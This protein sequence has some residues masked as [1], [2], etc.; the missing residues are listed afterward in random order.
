MKRIIIYTSFLSIFISNTFAQDLKLDESVSIKTEEPR[1]KKDI[2]ISIL[3]RLERYVKTEVMFR[4]PK[5]NVFLFSV[6]LAIDSIGHVENAFFSGNIVNNQSEFITVNDRLLADFK[7]MTMDDRAF[8]NKVLILPILYKR[9]ED[10]KV[11]NLTAF[12][13]DFLLIWPSLSDDKK[14]QT[15]LLEPFIINFLDPIRSGA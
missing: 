10:D 13:N 6:A 15:I 14:R 1:Q 4:K 11:S 3:N 9:P 5:N 7:N 12:L 8:T 2:R